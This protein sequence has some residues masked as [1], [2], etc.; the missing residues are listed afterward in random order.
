MMEYERKIR[1]NTKVRQIRRQ[2]VKLAELVSE[3]RVELSSSDCWKLHLAVS[4]VTGQR[5]KR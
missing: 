4:R 2:L 5:A 3:G 1:A